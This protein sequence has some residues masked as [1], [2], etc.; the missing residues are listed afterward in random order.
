MKAIETVYRGYKFRSR[1]EARWAV[2]FSVLGL[3]FEYEK[4]GYDLEWYTQAGGFYY[5]P[6]FWV[7]AWNAFVE[8]KGQE[9]AEDEL[10]KCQV[11][12]D[13]HYGK[14]GKKVIM[15]TGD[16]MTQKGIWFQ[17]TLGKKGFFN[18]DAPICNTREIELRQCSNCD[19]MWACSRGSE[20]DRFMLKSGER[21]PEKDGSDCW[22]SSWAVTDKLL[23]AMTMARQERFQGGM[24]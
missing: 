24:E 20:V 19:T 7:P 12:R 16:P 22:Q 17:C 5:L 18:N 9:P 3:D 11:L 21:C 8:I 2:F 23:N 4:E 6:D 10:E 15:F 13:S 1:L 14:K